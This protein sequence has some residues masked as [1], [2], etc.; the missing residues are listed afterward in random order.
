MTL[1]P[2]YDPMGHVS[3]WSEADRLYSADGQVVGW[4]RDGAV[5]ALGGNHVGWL[6]RGQFR[7]TAGCVVAW[8]PGALGGPPKPDPDDGR[9]R[10]TPGSTP[11]RPSFSR[12]MGRRP[13]VAE[14]SDR[15]WE[16]YLA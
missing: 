6:E 11:V 12:R 1:A 10:P 16:S 2:I 13:F 5:Y 15:S 8:L 4:L 14:W 9:R 7:D 3:G